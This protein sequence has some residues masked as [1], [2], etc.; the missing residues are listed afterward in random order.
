MPAFTLK[1]LSL[2]NAL[3]QWRIQDFHLGGAGNDRVKKLNKEIKSFK[4][5]KGISRISPVRPH[6]R[7]YTW[8]RPCT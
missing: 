7:A 6:L 4:V 8:V 3:D 1:W 2:L 5:Y